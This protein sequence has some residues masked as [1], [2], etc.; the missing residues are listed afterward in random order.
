MMVSSGKEA[1]FNQAM[2]YSI[3]KPVTV[4]KDEQMMTVWQ[5]HVSLLQ[6]LTVCVSTQMREKRRLV[7]EQ[8]CHYDLSFGVPDD[9]SS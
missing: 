4:L 8:C 1:V 2:L 9:N 6:G 3:R 5:V 7:C